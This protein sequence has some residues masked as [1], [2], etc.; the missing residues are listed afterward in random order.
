MNYTV[1]KG[2]SKD[3]Q[4]LKWRGDIIE[5]EITV[6]EWGRT[7]KERFLELMPFISDEGDVYKKMNDE[8]TFGN[9]EW[10]SGTELICICQVKI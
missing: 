3:G 4:K 2:I 6:V 1:E 7:R 8:F 10:V 9:S 5:N